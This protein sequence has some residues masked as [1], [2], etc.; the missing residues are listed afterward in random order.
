[1]PLPKRTVFRRLVRNLGLLMH[2]HQV[3]PD[4]LVGSVLSL[5]CSES[6]PG[7]KE[8][9]LPALAVVRE[10]PAARKFAAFLKA[11]DFLE[12]SYWLSS[13]YALLS[14]E[15]ERKKLAMYF[16]PP[17]LTKRLLDDLEVS[18]VEFD[19]GTFCDPACGGAAFL[20]PI[21][22][23]IRD[24]LRARGTPPRQIIRHVHAHLLGFDKDETLCKLSR[25]F[26]VMALRDEVLAAQLT[27]AFCVEQ[28]NSLLQTTRVHGTVDVVVCNPPFRKMA[29][30]EAQLYGDD[31]ADVIEAQPNIYALFIGL[32]VK[33]LATNGVCALV[34]PT[35]FL[36]G[37]YFS[38]VR[39]LLL[40]ETS[41][42]SIGMVGDR[43]GVFIDVEQETALT[44]A[45]RVS[46]PQAQGTSTDVCVVS[47]H[48]DYVDVGQCALPNSGAAWPIP[49]S[50]FDVRLLRSAA[51][52]TARI[53]NYGY[54]VRIGSFVWNRDTR[55]V[56][57]SAKCAAES[58]DGPAVPLLWSSDVKADGVLVFDGRPKSNKEPCFVNLGSKSH[59]SVVRRPSVLLQRVTSNDQPKRL[60]AA[61]VPK[62]FI[63]TYGGFV[64]E[65]HTVILEQATDHPVLPPNLMAELLRVP[66][67][68][69]YFR[70]I[71][72]ATN[73]SAFE[74]N[75][76]V[77]P[78][79]E[80]LLARLASGMSMA[81]AAQRALDD[82]PSARS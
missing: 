37:Q 29:S 7:L 19:K 12:G 77:L 64:G 6:F 38:K 79:P 39:T 30:A 52:S 76:L 71:S 11:E 15:S 68:D 2:E 27:P 45:R 25:H 82:L 81:D 28:A 40:T 23:R 46:H 75:Q 56:Y 72:G 14:G 20:A 73:V 47:R 22:L 70:C 24:A 18:G 35:S 69:R 53:A 51:N 78:S 3:G 50:E 32:C 63:D 55:T 67:T 36:S 62:E 61:A 54:V 42:L 43:K 26:L 49:R 9:E 34:T 21:A 44:I 17:S 74:L 1:M 5:W 8:S 16:T 57:P 10:S 13:A 48:G 33:L 58:K 31:Y 4:A 41:I 80:L 65:N 66:T 60:I 59:A